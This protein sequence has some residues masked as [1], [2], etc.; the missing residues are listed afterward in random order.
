MNKDS[1]LRD[2]VRLEMSYLKPVE[3][4]EPAEEG[5]RPARGRG[6]CVSAT[7]PA[8]LLVGLDTVTS[9]LSGLG[10]SNNRENDKATW[11]TGCLGNSGIQAIEA[12]LLTLEKLLRNLPRLGGCTQR[13]RPGAHAVED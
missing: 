4:E 8:T 2:G 7:P 11:R 13:V 10:L 1:D 6:R 12:S 3:E 9:E 5:Q